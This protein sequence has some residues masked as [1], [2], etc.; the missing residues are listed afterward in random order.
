MDN[1]SIVQTEIP[2][3]GFTRLGI[4]F[5]PACSTAAKYPVVLL[6]FDPTLRDYILLSQTSPSHLLPLPPSPAIWSATNVKDSHS[7]GHIDLSITIPD[8]AGPIFGQATQHGTDLFLGVDAPSEFDLLLSVTGTVI[9][10]IYVDYPPL[11]PPPPI[12]PPLPPPPIYETILVDGSFP[13]GF[14]YPPG[15]LWPSQVHTFYPWYYI[16][17]EY[18]KLP[19]LAELPYIPT[20]LI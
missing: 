7:T 10:S 1:K 6:E 13:P 20:E 11:M 12:F 4:L 8:N 16:L 2:L 9:G 15:F 3:I 18:H 17:Y 14:E 19:I 5:E